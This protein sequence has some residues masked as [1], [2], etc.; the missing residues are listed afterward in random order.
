MDFPPSHHEA[1]QAPQWW[2]SLRSPRQLFGKLLQ[3]SPKVDMDT[4]AALLP[5][6]VA[7]LLLSPWP[8]LGS[9]QGQFSAGEWLGLGWRRPEP[10]QMPRVR[11]SRGVEP[12][13]RQ[14]RGQG[15][16]GRLEAGVAGR[17][18]D[19]PRV[20]CQVGR[21]APCWAPL[22]AGNFHLRDALFLR[23]ARGE[24]WQGC[25][26]AWGGI[27]FLGE[28]VASA[29]NSGCTALGKRE[30]KSSWDPGDGFSTALGAGL[31]PSA[32]RVFK[33]KKISPGSLCQ[34]RGDWK[35]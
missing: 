31:L 11:G 30:R 27:A 6:W 19:I 1:S 10:G 7:L 5:A 13:P 29:S 20:L 21:R 17:G 33:G 26:G 32:A 9:A 34:K 35:G 22:G 12:A 15:F 16:A 24:G 14:G 2:I 23:L 4:A 28:L 18:R 3:S 25:P 8:L